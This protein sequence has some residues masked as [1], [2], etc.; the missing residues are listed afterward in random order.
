MRSCTVFRK[1]TKLLSIAYR[2]VQTQMTSRHYQPQRLNKKIKHAS[3]KSIIMSEQ[4]CRAT[5]GISG[6]H[7][8]FI[9]MPAL[10]LMHQR[11]RVE[12]QEDAKLSSRCTHVNF[13]SD[14]KVLEFVLPHKMS[15]RTVFYLWCA[16]TRLAAMTTLFVSSVQTVFSLLSFYLQLRIPFSA[17]FSALFKANYILSL[18][19]DTLLRNVLCTSLLSSDQL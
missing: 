2:R 5:A 15:A 17:T 8:A 11:T 12:V 19:E 16:Q 14:L 7:K 4:Y 3:C 18:A 13:C 6:I 10:W 1:D 9:G